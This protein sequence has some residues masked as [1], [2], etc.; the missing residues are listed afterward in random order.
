MIGEFKL[1]LFDI[2]GTL[3]R[4][5]GAGREAFNRTFEKVYGIGSAF[6]QIMMM[7]RT[8]SGILKE[9]LDNHGIGWHED[10]VE[11]FRETYYGY[12]V[13]EIEIPRSGKRLCPGVVELLERLQY[14]KLC[15]LGLLTGNWRHS[16]FIKLRYFG[17]DEYFTLGAFADDSPHRED[18]VPIALNTLNKQKQLDLPKDN[19]FV[20]G[21]TPLDIQCAKPHGV[22]TVGVATGYHSM[23]DLKAEKPDFVFENLSK[24]DELIHVFMENEKLG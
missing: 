18:L 1:L 10:E 14:E 2:D 3:M 15:I 23:K 11:N 20:I 6:N 21:D 13:E 4:T 9:A 24:V 19:V 5:A 17:I 8:D 7:G 16:S 12:L 22:R